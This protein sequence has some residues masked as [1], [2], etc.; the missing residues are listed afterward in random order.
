MTVG[1]IAELV[2]GRDD[3][4]DQLWMSLHVRANKKERG[5][6]TVTLKDGDKLLRGS[7]LRPIIDSQRDHIRICIDP[8][9][10]AAEKL[11]R[12]RPDKPQPSIRQ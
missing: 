3:G 10:Q 5:P 4:L 9:D 8:R 11:E 2:A 1:M 6:D 7:R 12:P